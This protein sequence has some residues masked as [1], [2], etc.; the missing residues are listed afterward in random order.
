M[1]KR[2]DESHTLYRSNV[3]IILTYQHLIFLGKRLSIKNTMQDEK[4]WQ[5]PQGGIDIG[6]TPLQAALREL[7][8]EIGTNNVS[9]LGESKSWYRYDFPKELQKNLWQGKFKGQRQ[10]WFLMEFT[11]ALEEIQLQTEYPEFCDMCWATPR[12]ALDRVVSFKYEVYKKVFKELLPHDV[13][14]EP[15]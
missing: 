1:E 12:Q 10:K 2:M 7:K 8:E 15:F 5:M 13:E 6:E 14:R 4:V 11:G 3:G 9:V